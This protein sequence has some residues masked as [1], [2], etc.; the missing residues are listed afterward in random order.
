LAGV[1]AFFF[2]KGPGRSTMA[3]AQPRLQVFLLLHHD[4]DRK[5]VPAFRAGASAGNAFEPRN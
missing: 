5:R 1:I 4:L 3:E 2:A